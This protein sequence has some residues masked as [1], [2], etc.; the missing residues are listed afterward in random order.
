MARTVVAMFNSFMEAQD[1]VQD[2]MDNGIPRDHISVVGNDTR[3]EYSR[4]YGTTTANTTYD[5][6]SAAA[7]GAGAGAVGGTVV[8]GVLGLL[9][10]IGAL[11]IPGIGPVIAAGPLIAAIGATAAGAGIGAAAGGLLGALVGAGVPEEDAHLYAEGVRRGGTL[12]TVTTDEATANRAYS[13]LHRHNAVDVDER[14]AAYRNEGWERFNPNAEPYNA[15]AGAGSYPTDS[16]RSEWSESSKVGTGTG[17]VAG[18]A[19]GAAIGAVGG[20]VGA[21]VGGVAGAATGAGVGA[22]GDAAGEA[23]EDEA[24]GEDDVARTGRAPTYDTARSTDTTDYDTARPARSTDVTGMG[25]TA[26][27]SG[28]D[29]PDTTAG[30]AGTT[31]GTEGRPLSTGTT[32]VST[33][34]TGYDTTG[35]GPT[36]YVAGEN[37]AAQPSR[38]QVYDS[39]TRTRVNYERTNDVGREVDSADSN[40]AESSKVGTATGG[41]AGAA[42]GAAIGAVGGPVGAVVG[43]AAGAVTGAGVGAAGDAAGEAAEDETRGEDDAVVTDNDAVVSDDAIVSDDADNAAP[44]RKG[45][46]SPGD[47]TGT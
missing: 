26:A 6:D 15:A 33:G 5:E 29:R 35:A 13:V 22:A 9:V 10:G 3:G 20:P 7:E 17:T 8:G 38:V 25:N 12:V 19:T 27:T 16:D 11:A 2:L 42:T 1:A 40:Y 41:V 30:T 34:T 31:T 4:A 24:R 39:D 21:A 46:V 14:G 45:Q 28:Y 23:T 47:M 36:G 44:G 18:A 43:G 32:G 37:D